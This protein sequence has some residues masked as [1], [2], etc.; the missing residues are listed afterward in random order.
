MIKQILSLVVAVVFMTM[1]ANAQTSSMMSD[2]KKMDIVDTAASSG[3]FNTL[4]AGQR[5]LPCPEKV[6]TNQSEREQRHDAYTE[7]D[8]LHDAAERV[9]AQVADA[10]APCDAA[11]A[12]AAERPD[13]E[14][15][16]QP[17]AQ[18]RGNE[19]AENEEPQ[20]EIARLP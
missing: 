11:P 8:H 20:R 10:E 7:G 19:S 17:G 12:H 15:C 1:A 14:P 13:E 5:G 3:M 2:G 6:A 4:V 18:H 9:A 16:H